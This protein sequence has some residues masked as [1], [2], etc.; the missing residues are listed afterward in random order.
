M[1]E[2]R[3][4]R[5]GLPQWSSGTTDSPSR[6]DFNEAFAQ[7]EALA[8][9]GE[10]GTLQ[11]RP[12]PGVVN[13]LYTDVDGAIYRDTGVVWQQI[14]SP[15]NALNIV[16]ESGTEPA[17]RA[18][19]PSGFTADA[20]RTV[21]NG[22]TRFKVEAN[23]DMVASSVRAYQSDTAAPAANLPTTFGIIPKSASASGI[24][25]W[26][27]PGQ[28]GN[29]LETKSSSGS[30]LTNLSS[31]GDLFAIGR[32]S[33][34][35]ID[36][37]A[38]QL[39]VKGTQESRP[40]ILAR[41]TNPLLGIG[42]VLVAENSDGTFQ[43]MKLDASG[44]L[45]VGHR[46]NAA[47]L[48][49][50][51]LAL[52]TNVTGANNG[53]TPIAVG[54]LAFRNATNGFGV[55][56]MDAR[57][58][59]G[60]GPGSASLGIY[61]GTSA[62]NASSPERA[63]FG[64]NPEKLGARFTA[65]APDWTPLTVKAVEG[66]VASLLTAQRADGTDV[67]VIANDGTIFGRSF[68]GVS[69]DQS[70]IQGSFDAAGSIAGASFSAHQD[71]PGAVAGYKSA[72][73]RDATV[74]SPHFHAT[75]E[76]GRNRARLNY[77]GSLELGMDTDALASGATLLTMRGQQYRQFGRKLQSYDAD[78]GRWGSFESAFAAEYYAL[79]AQN[80]K[81]QWVAIN[82]GGEANDTENAFGHTAGQAKIQMPFTGWYDV[83]A[84]AHVNMNFT[85]S[86]SATFRINNT[87][88]LKY[89]R[90]YPRALGWD[91]CTLSLNDL[92]YLN[93]NDILEFMIQID[94]YF[95]STNT[96]NTG[97]YRSRLSIRFAGNA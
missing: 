89:R 82:W 47:V 49:G 24:G 57:Q 2:T 29:L 97:E 39:F 63:R 54:R 81:N 45:A 65:S 62:D 34:G 92:V 28:T 14:G 86:G 13:R 21:H 51:L 73:R 7:L 66:Q 25:V 79:T 88:E 75:D 42:P 76:V 61:A 85:G 5:L 12:A 10:F 30:A 27:N 87:L 23:G 94:S 33:F 48:P 41:S 8:V 26:G 55:A 68:Q 4:P 15:K 16:K 11:A 67:A 31:S 74:K 32:G 50:D 9:R 70:N 19:I 38:S 20:I 46:G 40:V 52:N 80:V 77:D 22:K 95:F 91:V 3:T 44:R 35:A 90:D 1:A 43:L 93:K 60:D 69:T 78:A 83:R 64:I 37:A 71:A 53:Q 6:E 18:E 72:I 59:P 36:A 96:L 56:G 84:L 17:I 58:E